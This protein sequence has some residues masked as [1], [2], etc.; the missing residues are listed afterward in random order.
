MYGPHPD[1]S[2]LEADPVNGRYITPWL[3]DNEDHCHNCAMPIRLAPTV[4]IEDRYW[5]H[6]H[7]FDRHCRGKDLEYVGYG[8]Y[9]KEEQ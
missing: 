6:I 8:I 2:L 9:K 5:F 7:T 1:A 3:A 4:K